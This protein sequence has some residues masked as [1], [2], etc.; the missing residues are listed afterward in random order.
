MSEFPLYKSFVSY[1]AEILSN[2]VSTCHS[3]RTAPQQLDCLDTGRDKA[4]VEIN[5]T[6]W[7]KKL[8]NVYWY[9]GRRESSTPCN[10]R[11]HMQIEKAPANQENIF[12]ILTAD[13]ANAHNTNIKKHTANAHNTT[14]YILFAARFF[15]GCIVSICSV[16]VLSNWGSCFINL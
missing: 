3:C 8:L 16:C 1:T 9:Y 5:L 12:I 10:L 11:K 4:T 13:G 6:S 2:T 15:F 7:F 14:K